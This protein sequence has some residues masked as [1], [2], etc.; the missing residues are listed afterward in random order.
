MEGHMDASGEPFR[1]ETRTWGIALYDQMY[2]GFDSL[3]GEVTDSLFTVSP[4]EVFSRTKGIR[5][6]R[7]EI[8]LHVDSPG[9][10]AA[11][12]KPADK[13]RSPDTKYYKWN[14]GRLVLFNKN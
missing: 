4:H 10:I 7:D 3:E 12:F 11:T 5:V 1:T 8:W 2:G 14:G 13:K 6:D 9:T